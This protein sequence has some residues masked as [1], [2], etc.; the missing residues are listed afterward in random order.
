M[1]VIEQF[2]A[3]KDGREEDCEDGVVVTRDFAA[4]IDGATDKTGDQF[5][6]ATGGRAAMLACAGAVQALDPAAGSADAVASLSLAVASML[7]PGLPPARRPSA[8]V[9]IYSALRHEI[10]QVGDVGFWHADLSDHVD[11]RKKIDRYCSR[12]RSAVLRAELAAGADP[13]RLAQDDPGRAAIAS[14]LEHQW[15]FCNNAGAQEWAYGAINGEPVPPGL[16]GIHQV[17]AGSTSVVLASDGYP[18]ILPTLAASEQ[19]LAELLAADPLC[20]GPL[21][22]TKGVRPGNVSF[23]DRAY[24]R[25]SP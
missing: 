13:G 9:T 14:L 1:N 25:L 24:V 23:D 19:A 5:D 8:V 21:C 4:V 17:P 15:V 12:L 3:S 16:V 20:I 11:A 6:G 7:P 18:R 22:G 10:W 2:I